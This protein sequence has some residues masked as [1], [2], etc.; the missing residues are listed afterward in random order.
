MVS[1]TYNEVQSQVLFNAVVLLSSTVKKRKA[2]MCW[3]NSYMS[4]QPVG[5]QFEF[6]IRW[7]EWNCAVIL[8]SGQT[9]TLVKLDVLQFHSFAFASCTKKW[10]K[11][12]A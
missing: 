1:Y 11:I 5:H 2:Q 4:V 8:K 12:S 9:N 6:T 10:V 3:L 7:N